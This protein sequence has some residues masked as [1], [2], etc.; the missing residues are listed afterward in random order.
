MQIDAEL[1]RTKG[2]TLAETNLNFRRYEQWF[3]SS[4]GAEI[5]QTLTTTG[6]GYAA[7]AF[8]GSRSEAFVSELVSADNGRTTATN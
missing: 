2:V 3:Y 4:E 1:R 7:Y 5:H 8:E 6:A